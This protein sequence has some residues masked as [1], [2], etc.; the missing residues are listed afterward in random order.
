[1]VFKYL[2]HF[3]FDLYLNFLMSLQ[4]PSSPRNPIIDNKESCPVSF[5]LDFLEQ[6]IQLSD[7]P[8]GFLL[9]S[10]VMRVRMA[11]EQALAH[12]EYIL[13]M[14]S[15]DS[16]T[17]YFR[18]ERTRGSQSCQTIEEVK[19]SENL[20][21]AKMGETIEN[22]THAAAPSSSAKPSPSG[23][24]SA[25]IPHVSQLSELESLSLRSISS[26][27]DLAPKLPKLGMSAY[28]ADDRI[29]RVD[30]FE[31]PASDVILHDIEPK[32]LTFL[33]FLLIVDQV[34]AEDKMY[35]VFAGQC[36]WFA[37][38]VFLLVQAGFCPLGPPE[39]GPGSGS[40]QSLDSDWV[41]ISRRLL[42]SDPD[43]EKCCLKL[44]QSKNGMAPGTWMSV[45][46]V[47]VQVALIRKLKSK[48][49][50]RWTETRRKVLVSIFIF[51][52]IFN[53]DP[54]HSS[55]TWQR[56]R[57]RHRRSFKIW[58]WRT[59][60][61]GRSLRLLSCRRNDNSRRKTHLEIVSKGRLMHLQVISRG[62]FHE[63]SE[64]GASTLG[65][66]HKGLAPHSWQ[67][68]HPRAFV[69]AIQSRAQG[70]LQEYL[71]VLEDISDLSILSDD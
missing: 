51:K 11:K 48:F 42:S 5:Y 39:M 25:D 71:L 43:L 41:H 19:A 65:P 38:L 68:T 24:P 64:E 7:D 1:M 6:A 47:Q 3:L 30:S 63:D 32:N 44:E 16:Q 35:S 67:V 66:G 29:Y 34:H 58:R 18:I 45:F 50:S 59:R 20:E 27:N 55:R 13:A 60:N 40:T 46:V 4:P 2:A 28:L 12:H 31:P 21:L 61:F 57:R 36:Y 53:D 37:H 15:I 9:E 10:R 52:S 26:L 33:Q 62:P 17:Y 56:Q 8:L 70:P 23:T 54:L 49:D 22:L 69:F 14:V